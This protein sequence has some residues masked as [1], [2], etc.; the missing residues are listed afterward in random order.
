[1]FNSLILH[2]EPQRRRTA[3]GHDAIFRGLGSLSRTSEGNAP[4]AAP[5]PARKPL[6]EGHNGHQTASRKTP[7]QQK[8]SVPFSLFAC[9]PSLTVSASIILKMRANERVYSVARV[10]EFSPCLPQPKP[11]T[12]A[13]SSEGPRVGRHAVKGHVNSYTDLPPLPGRLTL[14]NVRHY[15]QMVRPQINPNRRQCHLLVID[16]PFLSLSTSS[17]FM[18]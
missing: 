12:P 8:A 17:S 14:G 4:G 2:R 1:M 13:A 7:C 11:R 6:S 9:S 3:A 15:R 5:R 10:R 18:V 16:L